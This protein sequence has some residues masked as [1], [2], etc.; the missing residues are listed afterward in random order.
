VTET[1]PTGYRADSTNPQIIAVGSNSTCGSGTETPATF[2]NTPLTTITVS[3]N[4][5]AGAGVT[6]STVQ[7]TGEGSPSATPHT[8][9]SLPPGNY[10]CT[11]IIDP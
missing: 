1:V 5:L 2:H 9:G 10:T 3:T 6:E 7:C 8:T 11:V 4:S